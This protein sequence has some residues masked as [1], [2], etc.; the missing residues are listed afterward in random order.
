MEY[1]THIS[2]TAGG[3]LIWS[4]TPGHIKV[5]DSLPG[6]TKGTDKGSYKGDKTTL[7]RFSQLFSSECRGT[8]KQLTT[9]ERVA[10]RERLI[11]RSNHFQTSQKIG[12]I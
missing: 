8:K 6:L 9:E 1:E 12:G 11:E 3:V 2:I 5:L 10:L 4:N 7:R